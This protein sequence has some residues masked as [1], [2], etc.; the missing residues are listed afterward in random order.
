[1]TREEADP[2]LHGLSEPEGR[3]WSAFLRGHARVVGRMS[4][5]LE[6]GGGMPLTHYDVLRQL[7]LAPGRSLRMSEL[8]DR[9]LLSRPG[10][11]GVV[12]RLEAE[13]LVERRRCAE[14]GRGLD[15]VL[16]AEGRRR[17]LAAHPTHVGSIRGR[18]AAA[19]TDEEL[20]TLAALLGRL[21]GPPSGGHAAADPG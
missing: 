15:A 11:T 14:D 6:A 9:V 7:A 1:V 17:L 3:A 12:K 20:R 8:A 21:T 16:T 5:D 4:E 13:G 19:Y 18:F 10:L 2:E